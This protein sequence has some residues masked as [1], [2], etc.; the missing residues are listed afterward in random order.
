MEHAHTG[1]PPFT[2][3]GG[4]AGRNAVLRNAFQGIIPGLALSIAI[5]GAGFALRAVLGI[6]A[7]SPLILSLL[8]GMAV[9]NLIGTPQGVVDGVKF[10][11]RRVLRAGIVLLGLQ[12]TLSQLVAI[13]GAGGIVI[14]FTLAATFG[15][16]VW[17]GRLLKVDTGLTKLIAAGSSIC[18]ASAV[19]AANTVVGSDDED[20]AYAVACV[21]VFGSL[22]MVAMPAFATAAGMAPA[23]FGLWAGATIHEVAQVAGAAFAM[24]SEAGEVGTVAK[25]ARVVMLA[26]VVLALG[27]AEARRMRRSGQVAGNAAPPMPWFVIGFIA[28]V[29]IASTG[30]VQGNVKQVAGVATQVLLAV[31][32][33]AT[34]LQT[35]LG[36]LA[37]KGPRPAMLAAA[38]WV[39]ISLF[40]LGL[41]LM[42][43]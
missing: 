32:L 5:A 34:G 13:G 35:H 39:F 29:G 15:F 1:T 25:L 42:V 9:N 24:G 16:T 28:M 27:M 33:A 40:G 31:A 41:V 18:G 22:S 8:L 43:E 6:G 23:T 10:G 3:T 20:V 4:R 21:T 30:L 37:A 26:P 2:E 11:V 17:L 7:I 14:L 36:G 38:S 12:L 19:V